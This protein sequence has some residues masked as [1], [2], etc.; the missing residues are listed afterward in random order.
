MLAA[1]AIQ[2]WPLYNGQE[3]S[4]RYLDF[5]N[6]PIVIPYD[7]NGETEPIMKKWMDFYEKAIIEMTDYLLE[8]HPL[9]EGVKKGVHTKAVQARA[10]DICRGFLPAGL[11]TYVSWHTN[12]RQAH[13]HLKQMRHHP[14]SEVRIIACEILSELKGK[15]SSSF[16]H[17][18][19]PLDEKYVTKI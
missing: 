18:S 4:T 11:T 1:K 10:F 3:A 13:D 17:K 6:Q 19:Y 8:K 7:E 9:E 15:Y 5:K 12:L 2:D 14:L 16:L